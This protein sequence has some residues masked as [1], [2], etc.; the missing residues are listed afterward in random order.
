MKKTL[1]KFS[2]I[3]YLTA[4]RKFAKARYWEINLN[5]MTILC[6]CSEKEVQFAC[7]DFRAVLLQSAEEELMPITNMGELSIPPISYRL[8]S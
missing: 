2:S 5:D 3:I 4:F 8:S 7:K 6:D 1:L